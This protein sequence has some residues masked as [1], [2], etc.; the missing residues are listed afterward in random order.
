VARAAPLAEVAAAARLGVVPVRI[1]SPEVWVDDQTEAGLEVTLFA[2]ASPARLVARGVVDSTTVGTLRVALEQAVTTHGRILV[3][4]SEVSSIGSEGIRVLYRHGDNLC[5]VIVAAQSLL[6]KAL[7]VA[8]R[9]PVL[10]A[11]AHPGERRSPCWRGARRRSGR[12]STD[13]FVP[14]VTP[15]RRNQG[16]QALPSSTAPSG[17]T[18]SARPLPRREPVAV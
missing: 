17:Q 1:L 18:G 7:L 15:L 13:Q 3:D 12:L 6:H 16:Q 2:K 8:S 11:P 9:F 4:L 10:V 14:R 5:G